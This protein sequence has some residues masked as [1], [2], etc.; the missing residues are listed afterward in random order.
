MKKE[1]FKVGVVPIIYYKNTSLE[2]A[3]DRL[4]VEADRAYRDGTNILILSDRGVD[5]NHV[6]IPS[7][8]AVSAMQQHLIQTK[9]RTA[10]A[11]I[12]ESGEPREIHHF[13]TLLGYGACAINP[14]LAQDTIEQLVDDHLLDKDYYAAI[15]DYNSAVLHGIVKIASKMGISTIQ[16]Y[17]GSK[18]FEAIG[19]DRSVID[20]YFT[21]TVSRIGGI[22]IS[23]IENDVNELHSMAFDPLGLQTELT[24]DSKGHHKMRSGAQKHLYNPQ[25]IHLLQES[26]KR[27]DYDL[28]KEYTKLVNNETD[29]MNIRGTLD[30][31]YPKS[32][33]PIDEVESVDSIV[34]RFKTGAMSYGSISQEAHETLAIAM[35]RLHGK[36]NSGEGGESLER[37]D[38]ERCSAI[39][40]VASGRFGVTSRYLVSAQEI[41]IKMAQGAKPGE[42]GHLPGKKGISV[43]CK[44]K[45][46][47]TGR[48]SDLTAASSRYLLH[49]GFGTADL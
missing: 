41:Q 16:S 47:H 7:L 26:T 6:A 22:T 25:T 18:I 39:K 33:I 43:D 13:A 21:D 37:L 19:I 3:I 24:L 20:K 45:T 8:L 29:I 44:N 23:D 14:Y 40:Q 11:M 2:K 32:G 42:G 27:G 34:T 17:Q 38:T 12:L 46:F 49:R 10:V 5:E 48:K 9:K 31:K 35:N 1:G 4:F 28:F 15:N 30:F 36:S